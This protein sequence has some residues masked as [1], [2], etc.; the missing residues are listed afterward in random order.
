VRQ[1]DE[2]SS[3][4]TGSRLRR[5]SGRLVSCTVERPWTSWL[6]FGVWI[7]TAVNDVQEV[8]SWEL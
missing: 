2:A 4:D 3:R 6:A 1:I 8:E 5:P 7:L